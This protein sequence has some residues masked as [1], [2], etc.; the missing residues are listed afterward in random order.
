M[1]ADMG[2]N[3]GDT[4]DGVEE[5]CEKKSEI[6]D[7]DDED[8]KEVVKDDTGH[9]A[10]RFSPNEFSSGASTGRIVSPLA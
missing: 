5:S 6:K 3:M 4:R 2:G 8:A 9:G 1:V 10:T 7:V